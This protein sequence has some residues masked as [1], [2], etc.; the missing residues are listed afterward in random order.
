MDICQI[1][2]NFDAYKNNIA[3]IKGDESISY[4]E[5]LERIRYWQDYVKKNNIQKGEV[6]AL[7]GDFSTET[8]S[9]F[10][11]LLNHKC[12]LV[13]LSNKT[14]KG[15]LNEY[16]NI[17]Q[18]ESVFSI[19]IFD[20]VNF[21]KLQH[22][23]DH[24]IYNMLRQ[25]QHPGLVAFT[26]G[27]SG[28]PKAAVHDFYKLLAPFSKRRPA[29]R[30]I[31]F[32]LFDHLG[33]INTMLHILCFGGMLVVVED[34]TPD[35][36]CE[37]I[38]KH[39]VEVLPTSPTFLNY[40]LLSKAHERFDMSSLK[41]LTYGAEPMPEKTLKE[42]CCLF[43]DTK[44]KQTYGL[45]E[46]GA[47]KIKSKSPDSLLI[48]IG[49]VEWRIVDDILQIKCDTS[50]IGYLNA[51][52]PYTEDGYLITGDM[53]EIHGEYIKIIGR[54]SE[55]INIGGE[56]VF[57][58]EVENVILDMDN[59]AEVTVYKEKHPLTGNILCAKI[60]LIDEKERRKSFTWRL[61]KYC[62]Q[63]LESFKVPV[64]VKLSK[65]K[66]CNVRFKKIRYGI[67]K[68]K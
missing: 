66:Q 1:F 39:K 36:V 12:I 35:K 64:R 63:H 48:K 19:D 40:M 45:I 13:P 14:I 53:V 37:L 16:L 29:L 7:V 11:A 18:V 24:T 61:K 58:Q 5:L 15:K 9:L 47:F 65:Q 32:L 52:S 57:P 2:D 27:S 60:R 17:A 59:V 41:V 31:N 30:M 44:I 43:P 6:I 56:K 3:L 25:K 34:R 38:E 8:V 22:S 67:E 4:T 26:S 42:L 55:Q 68:I 46:T 51:P 20:T 49:D 50:M 54:Q 33:G 10:F 28:L 23:S 62:S 21:S